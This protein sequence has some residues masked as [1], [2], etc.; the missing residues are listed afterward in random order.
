[1]VFLHFCD[2]E[3]K[4]ILFENKNDVPRT[5]FSYE[6][7][8]EKEQGKKYISFSYLSGFSHINTPQKD[9]RVIYALRMT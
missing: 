3:Y 5:M 1:M 7:S 8:K 6:L 2:K 4:T 9:Y